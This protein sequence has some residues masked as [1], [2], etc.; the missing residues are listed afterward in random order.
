MPERRRF[1]RHTCVFPIEVA[2]ASHDAL[3][4]MCRDASADGMLFGTPYRLRVGESLRLSFRVSSL[5][6]PLAE[7]P[8]RVVRT[9]VSPEQM[10]WKVMVGVSFAPRED[11]V[12]DFATGGILAKHFIW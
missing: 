10:L 2:T 5:D 4:A 6:D 7:I 12:G 8:A 11:L 1:P 9:S 3:V